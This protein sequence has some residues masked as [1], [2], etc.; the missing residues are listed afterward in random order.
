VPC[1]G[2]GSAWEEGESAEPESQSSWRTE[3]MKFMKLGSKPDA[4]QSGGAD[5]R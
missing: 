2:G 5:V 3:K 1:R 4:F